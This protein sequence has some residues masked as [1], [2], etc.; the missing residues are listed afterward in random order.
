MKFSWEYVKIKLSSRKLWLSVIAFV[1]LVM[2]AIGL[3][4]NEVAQAGAIIM[5]GAVVIGYCI[6]NGLKDE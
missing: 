6:G 4:E 5:A 3:S 1:T 2:Q